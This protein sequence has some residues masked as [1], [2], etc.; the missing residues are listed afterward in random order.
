[1][2]SKG[3][4]RIRISIFP[5]LPT[6]N[7]IFYFLGDYDFTQPPK[8]TVNGKRSLTPIPV[9]FNIEVTNFDKIDTYNMMLRY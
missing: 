4:N 7:R 6:A 9:T 1:M 8:N 3:I 2:P 5:E